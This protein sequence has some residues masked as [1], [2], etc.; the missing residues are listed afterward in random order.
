MVPV[1]AEIGD[2]VG[3][4]A[5]IVQQLLARG[6]VRTGTVAVLVSINP[7]LTRVDANFLKI[8]CL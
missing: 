4:G 8:H 2:N 7:D 5:R 1:N 3:S 6:L